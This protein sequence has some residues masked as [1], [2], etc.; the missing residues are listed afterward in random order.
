MPVATFC[1]SNVG[2]RAVDFHV[3]W[4]ECRSKRDRSLLA[5]NQLAEVCIRLASG[6]TTNLTMDLGLTT[7]PP[8]D[9]L[10]CCKGLWFERESG[11]GRRATRF[12]DDS[13]AW[14]LNILGLYWTPRTSH[15]ANS[16]VFAANIGVADYFRLMHGLTRQQWLKD[17]AQTQSTPSGG[18]RY[19]PGRGPT[20][21]E[22]LEDEAQSAFAEFCQ[23]TPDLARDAESIAAPNAAPPHR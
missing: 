3:R 17:R 7:T 22:R 9:R 8:E 6:R 23:R 16:C 14:L 20:A 19:G 5:T 1:V 10:T 21:E 4:F 15:L 2:P 18:I 11:F 12:M 13:L